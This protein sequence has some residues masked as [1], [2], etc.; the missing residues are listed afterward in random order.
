MIVF[1]D[2]SP[3]FRSRIRLCFCPRDFL[4]F[5]DWLGRVFAIAPP[6]QIL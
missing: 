5:G 1:S 6:T 2:L 3:L 4:L